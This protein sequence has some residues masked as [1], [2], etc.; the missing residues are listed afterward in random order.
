MDW[1]S[2]KFNHVDSYTDYGLWLEEWEIDAPTPNITL[3]EIPGRDN[4]LDFSE[5]IANRVTYGVRS[6]I[7][8]FGIVGAL[9]ERVQK[10][11]AFIN[12]V[13]GQRMPIECS[14]LDGYFNG[15]VQVD[16][17]EVEEPYHTEL[18]VECTCNPYRYRNEQTEVAQAV[19]GSA[20]ITLTNSSMST[21]P[22]IVTDAPFTIAFSDSTFSVVAGTH[23]LPIVLNN[24]ENVITFTGDGNVTITYQEGEL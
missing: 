5:A 9:A 14:W 4:P 18:R 23:Y 21:T 10:E 1:K 16:R 11:T 20:T 17:V 22:T 2:V 24:G 6:L 15:R 13:H 19:S 3:V 12:A 8:Q 7:F